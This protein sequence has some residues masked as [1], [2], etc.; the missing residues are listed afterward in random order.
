MDKLYHD[1]QTKNRD[2]SNITVKSKFEPK[3]SIKT[4]LFIKQF[5]RTYSQKANKN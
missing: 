5:A 3:P 2:G 4:I 1:T